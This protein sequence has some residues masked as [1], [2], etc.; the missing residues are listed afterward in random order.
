MWGETTFA[1]GLLGREWGWE[2]ENLRGVDLISN[3]KTGTA[4]IVTAGDP[5]TGLDAYR[6][7]VRYERREI[8]TA[9]VNGELDTLWDAERGRADWNVWFLLHF[10][11]RDEEVVPAEL[12][13]P[14]AIDPVGN[15]TKWVERIIV[16]PFDEGP[17]TRRIDPV[18]SEPDEPV[19]HVRRRAN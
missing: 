1:L 15:V 14:A 7:Q 8:I 3:H 5:A 9:L 16:P 17:G 2:H 13:L 6:P 19:V 11:G 4:V 12:S 18:P 10:V